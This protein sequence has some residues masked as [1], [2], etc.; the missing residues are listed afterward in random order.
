[1]SEGPRIAL[2]SALQVAE[3][4]FDRWGLREVPD[5][6]Q[7]PLFRRI[8]ATM[9]T[10]WTGPASLFAPPIE[11]REP[12]GRIVR[13]LKPGF[14]AASLLVEPWE[15]VALPV[16]VYRYTPRNR[17]WM[18]IE[19]TGP[20]D[21]GRWFL[22]RWKVAH[23]IPVGDETRRASIDNH[24]VDAF[25]TVVPVADE[26]QAFRLAREAFIPPEHRDEVARRWAQE[27][28]A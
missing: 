1:M 13:G 23:R 10:P 20:A 12:V 18:L 19:R 16:Q 9:K 17:G 26:A 8:N 3:A 11:T 27:R 21:F 22:W 5:A 25:G 15:G 2:A 24:L 4:L 7:D 28:S 14:L 6:E